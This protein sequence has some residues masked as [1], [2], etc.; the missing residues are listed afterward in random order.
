M[1]AAVPALLPAWAIFTKLP[2][3]S[4]VAASEIF[5]AVPVVLASAVI[6]ITFAV[7]TASAVIS[8]TSASILAA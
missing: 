6:S 2:A 7:V 5:S 8:I 1:L 3:L 4:L